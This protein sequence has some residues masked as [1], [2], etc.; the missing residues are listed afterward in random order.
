MVKF[1]DYV[2]SQERKRKVR[3]ICSSWPQ[4]KGGK[5]KRTK[6]RSL[7]TGVPSKPIGSSVKITKTRV[8]KRMSKNDSVLHKVC[9]DY[10]NFVVSPQ[11][12]LTSKISCSPILACEMVEGFARRE[13][14]SRG[15]EG[16]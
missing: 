15:K 12:I 2:A 10:T 5:Q 9:S 14:A 11:Y 8:L 13:A 1:V 4:A 16:G 3:M 6:R 7:V